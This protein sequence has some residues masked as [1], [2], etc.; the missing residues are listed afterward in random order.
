MKDFCL[1]NLMGLCHH[2]VPVCVHLL[3][4]LTSQ[5]HAIQTIQGTLFLH[6][7]FLLLPRPCLHLAD[8]LAS[9]SSTPTPGPLHCHGPLTPLQLLV[10]ELTRTFK[11]GSTGIKPLPDTNL[12]KRLDCTPTSGAYRR[13][14]R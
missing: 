3:V 10:Y 11:R 9:A 8:P 6:P 12:D 14:F 5:Q 7:R 4:A 2:A 1:G 13:H